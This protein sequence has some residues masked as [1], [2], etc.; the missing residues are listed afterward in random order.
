MSVVGI[1]VD[2]ETS[3]FSSKVSSGVSD[4]ILLLWSFSVSSFFSASKFSLL[5]GGAAF[6]GDI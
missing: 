4:T 5:I 1:I 2:V 3:S 6:P